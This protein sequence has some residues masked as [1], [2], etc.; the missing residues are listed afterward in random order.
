MRRFARWTLSAIGA[1]LTVTAL[2]MAM[3]EAGVENAYRQLGK[4]LSDNLM[5]QTETTRDWT[6]IVD[7]NPEA[8]GWIT[9]EGTPI[10]YPVVQPSPSTPEAFYLT[11]DFWRQADS[12]GCP[13]LG[14]RARASGTHLLIFGH[15]LGPTN[16]MFGALSPAW[17]QESFDTLGT[18]QLETP[19]G[20]SSFSPLLALKVDR[21]FAD[22]QRFSFEND[23]EMRSWLSSLAEQAH[24][25][26]AN[27]TGLIE[28]AKRVLTLVTCA[29]MRSGERERTLVVF[30]SA[31]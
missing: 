22:I 26:H 24:A 31:T 28:Q 15:R 10:D 2:L 11:H 9:V 4:Q 27:E 23:A 18:A 29:K 30:V 8:V 12:A 7:E 3:Q 14:V 25:R 16:R 5:E 20:S 6:R 13:Y 21:D 17:R 1:I 19:S